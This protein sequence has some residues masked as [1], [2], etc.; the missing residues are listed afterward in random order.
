MTI[1][2][3]DNQIIIDSIAYQFPIS[4]NKLNEQIGNP[5]RVVKLKYNTIMTWDDLGIYC[6]SN[7]GT[8]IEY[9]NIHLAQDENLKF[10][11]H[12]LFQGTFLIEGKSIEDRSIVEDEIIGDISI[13]YS[14]DGDDDKVSACSI[15]QY[16]PEVIED[17]DRYVIKETSEKSIPFVDFNFKLAV[18]QVLMYERELMKPKFDLYEFVKRYTKRSI[19]LEEEGYDFI[20]EVN[21]YFKKLP[22]Y[23]KYAKEV[24]EIYQDGGNDI[25]LQLIN[26]W[27]GED[28]AFD[29][30]TAEDAKYFS[31]LKKVTLFYEQS[32][33][34]KP[35][36]EK[37]GIEVEYL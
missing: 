21:D 12:T 22:V 13:Y 10:L 24:T 16:I 3:T 17:P 23:E 4:S 2:I 33:T 25:Y 14:R 7:D 19:D 34:V 1:E 37:M 15:G 5:S 26:F 27:H 6:H 36:L 30:K 28:D 8:I 29:I 31:N 9:I 35:A 20:P 11:P 18:I 32:P